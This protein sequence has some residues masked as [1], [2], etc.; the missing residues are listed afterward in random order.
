MSG[1]TDL[2]TAGI[3]FISLFAAITD[4]LRGRIY[5]WLTLPALLAGLVISAWLQGW[6]GL[7]DALLGVFL[8]LLM[9]GWMFF[10]VGVMGAGDVKFLMA[11]GAWGGLRFT[12]EVGIL[13]VLLGGVMAA[14][15]L[16]FQ[17]KFTDFYRK[18][19]RFL[20]SVLVKELEVEPPKVD[21]SMTMPYGIAIAAAA[22]WVRLGD[23]FTRLGVKLW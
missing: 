22:I 8:G 9:Y 5:N 19:R 1:R 7:G 20:L 18:M 3:L 10:P 13:G 4:L 16:V 6:S 12:A 14:A 23:P 15:I 11:L 2:L 17:G 21:R